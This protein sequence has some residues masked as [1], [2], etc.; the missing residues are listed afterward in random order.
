MLKRS[1]PGGPTSSS[2][3]VWL[4]GALSLPVAYYTATLSYRYYILRQRHTL[5]L[6]Y[7]SD[8]HSTSAP[9][10]SLKEA[11]QARYASLRCLFTRRFLNVTWEW[12]EQGIWEWLFH[13][14]V[15]KPLT[16]RVWWNGGVPKAL[17]SLTGEGSGSTKRDVELADETSLPI[18]PLDS[19]RL[20]GNSS[21]AGTSKARSSPSS[22]S[23]EGSD[24]E[25]WEKLEASRSMQSGSGST[26][27]AAGST[28]R[29]ASLATATAPSPASKEATFTW[30][31]QSTCLVQGDGVT[32]LTDP[33]F[34]DKPLETFLAPSRL[35]PPACPL[36]ELLSMNIVDLCF[37]S[38][39]HF[40]HLDVEVVRALKNTVRWVVPLGLKGFFLDQG[41][42]EGQIDELDWWEE[43][44]I[45]VDRRTASGDKTSSERAGSSTGKT[46]IRAV[47]TP[48]Q[49]W[50]GRTPLD[51]NQ[52]LWSGFI[53]KFEES[54]KT[55]FHCGDTGYSDDLFD[56]L[57]KVHGPIDLA[58][59][60][61]GSYEPRWFMRVVHTDPE[62]AVKIHK[63]LQCAKTVGVHWGTWII[64]DERYDEPPQELEKQLGLLD[65]DASRFVTLP[66]GRTIAWV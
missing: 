56:A 62:G 12:R 27:T 30:I 66:I 20:V 5:Y 48:A 29:S 63:H 16:G 50:S 36:Q 23:P 41:V 10:A 19:S 15:W 53:V 46:A 13:Q 39:N 3:S 31:G 64:S 55:F 11:V 1:G 32:I 40:D 17:Q 49:H 9:Y 14:V 61:I 44:D 51:T 33:V 35:R 25:Q 24:D 4:V 2:S 21:R 38:H 54:D 59:I 60:P 22:G 47:C 34:S 28:T 57:G 52:S 7:L 58:A 43:R 26:A 18:E 65:V 45:V 6:A 8:P 42:L 37:V